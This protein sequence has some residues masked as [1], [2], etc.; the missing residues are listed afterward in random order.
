[1]RYTM[2]FAS[3]LEASPDRVWRW[4][5]SFD[6]IAREMA[7][8]LKM[9]APR[10]VQCLDDVIVRPGEPLFRSWIKL[11]GVLPVDYSDLTLTRMDTGKGFQEASPMGSMKLWRHHREIIPQDNG[12]RLVDKL[13]FEPRVLPGLSARIVRAFFRHRHRRLRRYL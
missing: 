12:C 10:G 3:S 9:S 4:I 6:G 8:W 2:E 11:F 5:V 13:E 7:P 1:M